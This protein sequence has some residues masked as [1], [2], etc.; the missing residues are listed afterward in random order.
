MKN[1]RVLGSTIHKEILDQGI[2]LDDLGSAIGCTATQMQSIF[3]G[4][5][6]CSFQQ[7]NTLADILG[8]PITQLIEGDKQ[9]YEENVVHCMKHFTDS[10]NR[11][12]ILDIIY[13]YLDVCDAVSQ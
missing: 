2:P 9:Y 7:I 8:L 13:D 5:L 12:R 6:L 10:E 1:L 11:E 4:R 3:K